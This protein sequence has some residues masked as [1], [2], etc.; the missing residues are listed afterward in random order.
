MDAE[1]LIEIKRLQTY[2]PLDE[3]TV[4]AVD[5]A[6]FDIL[7][8]ETLG[9]VGESGSGKSV[10]ARSILRILDPPGRIVSGE[11][12]YHRRNGGKTNGVIDLATLNPRGAEIR[13]IRGAEI[14]MIFQEPM[15]ALSPVYTI[16]NQIIEG[17]QQHRP[18]N[19]RQARVEAIDRC[20]MSACRCPNGMWMRIHTN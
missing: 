5:G 14:A 10:L 19:A 13:S 12:L 9:I 2:F 7:R 6:T 8:G 16:G 18:V 1:P 11:L 15:T 17:I 20:A 4:K 3:G